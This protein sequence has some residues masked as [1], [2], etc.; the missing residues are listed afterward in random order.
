[1]SAIT[2]DTL[3]LAKKLE[4]A[5]FTPQQAAGAVEA[6]S[7]SFSE[8][9]GLATKQDVSDLRRDLAEA[10]ADLLKWMFGALAAQTAFLSAIKF[11][12]H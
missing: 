4:A 8:V 10:K 2:F 3:K 9:S 7:E 11:F 12:G 5:G 6:V 1:M